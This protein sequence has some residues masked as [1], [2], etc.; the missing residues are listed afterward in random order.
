MGLSV[1][2]Q[3]RQLRLLGKDAM[4]DA[5]LAGSRNTWPHSQCLCCPGAYGGPLA[6]SVLLGTCGEGASPAPLPCVP[7]P[8][9]WAEVLGREPAQAIPC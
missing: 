7:Q 6:P 3:S 5:S 8:S 2:C 1:G 9:S 4:P